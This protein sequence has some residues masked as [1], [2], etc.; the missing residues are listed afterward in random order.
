MS[1]EDFLV[2]DP[3]EDAVQLDP[4]YQGN[5]YLIEEALRQLGQ[6]PSLP[7]YTPSPYDAALSK[8]IDSVPRE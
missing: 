8:L 5:M 4:V 6:S 2:S 3:E 7:K 1:L